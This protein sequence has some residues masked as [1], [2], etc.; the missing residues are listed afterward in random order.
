MLSRPTESGTYKR[1]WREDGETRWRMVVVN[2]ELGTGTVLQSARVRPLSYWDR[3]PG[4]WER[5]SVPGTKW[6]PG[7]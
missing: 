7:L 6:R 2:V 4:G 5:V 3:Q 1:V